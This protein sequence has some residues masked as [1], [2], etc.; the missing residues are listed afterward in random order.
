MKSNVK[1]HYCG[2]SQ[3]YIYLWNL[4]IVE[5]GGVEREKGRKGERDVERRGEKERECPNY[6]SLCHYEKITSDRND[7]SLVEPLAKEFG[8]SSKH[9]VV[10]Q[11]NLLISSNMEKWSWTPTRSFIPRF[12]ML[13]SIWILSGEEMFSINFI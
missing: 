3:M 5:R 10:A 7:L 1:T 11:H 4:S 9:H 6:T 13:E 12:I 2:S 8:D